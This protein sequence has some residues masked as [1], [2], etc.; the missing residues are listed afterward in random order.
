MVWINLAFALHIK[1]GKSLYVVIRQKV[2]LTP[3][4]RGGNQSQPSAHK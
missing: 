3:Q 4:G 1:T 2:R